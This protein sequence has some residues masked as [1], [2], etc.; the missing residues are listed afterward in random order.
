MRHDYV[1]VAKI[2]A[3][4]ADG[5]K[6]VHY[7][8]VSAVEDAISILDAAAAK[9]G[10]VDAEAK[11]LKDEAVD[12]WQGLYED[13]GTLVRALKDRIEELETHVTVLEAEANP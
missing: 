9:C 6:T 7:P 5:A 11:S 10:Q 3:L 8:I 1:T 4:Y 12:Y 2:A 13:Q